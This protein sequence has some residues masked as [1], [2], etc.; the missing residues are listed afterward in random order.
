MSGSLRA[1]TGGTVDGKSR[2]AQVR[3]SRFDG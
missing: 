3:R 2:F 1:R